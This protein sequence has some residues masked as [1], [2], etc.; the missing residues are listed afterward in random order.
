[1]TYKRTKSHDIAQYANKMKKRLETI[2][3]IIQ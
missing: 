1:M 3:N 2:S